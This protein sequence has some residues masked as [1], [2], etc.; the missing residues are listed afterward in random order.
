MGLIL[1]SAT[2]AGLAQPEDLPEPCCPCTKMNQNPPPYYIRHSKRGGRDIFNQS[3]QIKPIH[4]HFPCPVFL[5]RAQARQ[6]GTHRPLQAGSFHLS[7]QTLQS[8]LKIN[9]ASSPDSGKD[10]VPA[11]NHRPAAQG[12]VQL[13]RQRS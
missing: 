13:G 5:V 8:N 1:F 10:N 12:W 2:S 9:K 6:S 4:S 3:G 7:V 11:G